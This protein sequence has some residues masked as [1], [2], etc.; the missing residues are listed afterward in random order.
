MMKDL[1]RMKRN[2]EV[3]MKELDYEIAVSLAI[4]SRSEE[5]IQYYRKE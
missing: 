2:E 3:E 5:M 1:Y 4:L